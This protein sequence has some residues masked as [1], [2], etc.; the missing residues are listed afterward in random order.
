MK[1]ITDAFLERMRIYDPIDGLHINRLNRNHLVSSMMVYVNMCEDEHVYVINDETGDSHDNA[2]VVRRVSK[3][4]RK[5]STKV[6]IYRREMYGREL[7]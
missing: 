2:T 3:V 1:D 4:N 7:T 6:S 5:R